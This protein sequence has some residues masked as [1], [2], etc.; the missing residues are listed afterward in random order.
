MKPVKLSIAIG[1]LFT[2][3]TAHDTHHPSSNDNSN[4]TAIT[5]S[6]KSNSSDHHHGMSIVDD[7][8]LEPQQKLYWQ[9]YNTTSFLNTPAPNK[10]FLYTHVALSLISWI[11]VYPISVMLSTNSTGALGAGLHLPVQTLHS[12]TVILS[13]L[14][15]AI[16]GITAPSDMYPNNAYSKMSIAMFFIILIHWLAMMGRALADWALRASQGNFPIDGAADVYYSVHRR[17]RSSDEDSGW[18]SSS[19]GG[20]LVSPASVGE[21][22]NHNVKYSSS[23]SED[24]D[25]DEGEA[26]LGEDLNL[27]SSDDPETLTGAGAHRTRVLGRLVE[28]VMNKWPLLSTVADKCGLMADSIFTLINRPLFVFGFAYL[29]AG[30]ATN[31]RM[32]MGNKVFN[33][34]AHFIKGGVFFLFGI[35]TLSRYLGCFADQG[36]A[37]NIKPGSDLDPSNNNQRRKND[38]KIKFKF[39][40]TQGLPA[41]RNPIQ[42]YFLDRLNIPSMEFVESGLVFIYGASNIFL[43]RLANKDGVWNHKDLQHASI[44]FMYIGGGL[45]GLLVESTGIRKL[46]ARAVTG[47]SEEEDDAGGFVQLVRTKIPINPFPAFIV[48]WTGVLMSQH[49]QEFK[50]STLIHTQWGYLFCIGALFRLGTYVLLYL[51]PPQSTKPSRPFTELIVSFCLICGGMVFIQSNIQTVEGMLYR[52]LDA[53]FSLNINVGVAA[54]IMAWEMVVITFRAWANKRGL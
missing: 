29:L 46:L 1:L 50:L 24:G 13:L 45:C 38:D 44:A 39:P 30:V 48:F 47:S 3:A 22:A 6:P 21:F 27:M 35:L 16:Y 37:W 49:E 14:S 8:N 54:L 53:M 40:K 25:G 33:I 42:K 5:P 7:P 17:Q 20:A 23:S 19:I 4:T 41:K 52:G 32:A 26:F 12:I 15:L 34:L 51:S 43:E 18:G 28:K 2:L 10:G 11:V 36:M 31:F 9:Q